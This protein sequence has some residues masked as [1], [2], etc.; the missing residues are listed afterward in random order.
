MARVTARH[1]QRSLASRA[2]KKLMD[3]ATELMN[4]PNNKEAGDFYRNIAEVLGQILLW[5]KTP[6]SATMPDKVT[7]LLIKL[8]AI[9][10][11]CRFVLYHQVADALS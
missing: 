6:S 9:C 8:D 5:L 1:D 11:V 10:A 3:L 7:S 2:A 4:L